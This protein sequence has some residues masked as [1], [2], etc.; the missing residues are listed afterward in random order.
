MNILYFELKYFLQFLDVYH[1]VAY[2]HNILN[3]Y[4][5]KFKMFNKYTI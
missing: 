5:K 1:I 4:V 2:A 3:I